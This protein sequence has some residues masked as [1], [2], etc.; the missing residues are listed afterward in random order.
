M[1]NLL[2]ICDTYGTPSSWIG[3]ANTRGFAI[4][5]TI[6]KMEE[7]LISQGKLSTEKWFLGSNLYRNILNQ[8]ILKNVS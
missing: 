8:N 3:V 6:H 5:Y 1:N 4:L 7:K 2:K